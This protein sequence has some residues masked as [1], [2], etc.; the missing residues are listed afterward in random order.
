MSKYSR[1]RV[2]GVLGMHRS[3]TSLCSRLVNLLG[4]SLGPEEELLGGG[5]DNPDGFWENVRIL[6]VHERILK[7]IGR[8][9][10]DILPLPDGWWMASEMAPFQREIENLIRNYVNESNVWA[11]K[12]PRN[13]ILLPLWRPV[14]NDLGLSPD[15]IICVRNPIDVALSLANIHGFSLAKSMCL[16]QLYNLSALHWT[17][18]SQRVLLSYDDLMDHRETCLSE[19]VVALKSRFGWPVAGDHRPLAEAVKSGLRHNV[20]HVED[21]LQHNDI[22]EP[23]K[24]LYVLLLRGARNPALVSA[25][26]FSLETGRLYTE[27]CQYAPMIAGAFA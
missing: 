26:A 8:F 14:L 20:H 24:R 1:S 19:L 3:G 7:K 10:H 21:V 17:R 23:V 9:W 4:A 25:R 12:D 11:W 6:D 13:G 2:I 18:G 27:Y 15:Y 22:P 16:W 5:P